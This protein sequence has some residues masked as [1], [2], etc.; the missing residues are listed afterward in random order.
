MGAFRPMRPDTHVESSGGKTQL[1]GLPLIF[2]TLL[3]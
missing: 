3:L 1:S 2:T